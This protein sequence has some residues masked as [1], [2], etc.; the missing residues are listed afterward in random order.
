M[1]ERRIDDVRHRLAS[2]SEELADIAT[3]LLSQALD[4]PEEHERVRLAG[5]ERGVTKAR[6]AVEKAA[7]DLAP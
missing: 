7:G 2:I 5:L 1:S 3:D 4:T 6:R